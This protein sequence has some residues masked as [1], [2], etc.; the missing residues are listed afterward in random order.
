MQ[1]TAS[2]VK[3]TPDKK[4]YPCLRERFSSD[5]ESVINILSDVYNVTS[6]GDIR[7]RKLEDR[8]LSPGVLYAT[9]E[10]SEKECKDIVD[11]MFGIP[12]IL[13]IN[14][15]PNNTNG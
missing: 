4:L 3:N 10:A 6:W 13:C 5:V 12:K 8:P 2:N 1:K 7:K 11:Y 15:N 9:T 14:I